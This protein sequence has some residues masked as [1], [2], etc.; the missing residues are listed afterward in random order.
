M[1]MSKTPYR[2]SFFGGGTDYPIWYKNNGGEVLSTTIDK[3]LYLTCRHLPPFF[4]HK[5]RIVWSQ[6]EKVNSLDE[7]KHYA[8]KKIFKYMKIKKG[9]ELHYDGDLPA[10]SGMG[11]SSAFVVGLMNLLHA[12]KGKELSKKVLA[13]KSLFIEQR[14]LNET[15]GSQ[16]QISTSY[17]GFNSIKFYKNKTFSVNSF[18]IKKKIFSKLEKNLFIVYSG[19]NRRA[20]NIASKYVY[21]LNKQKK[22]QMIEIQAFVKKAKIYLNKGMLDD[23]GYLIGESWQKKK[24]LSNNI[25]STKIDHIYSLAMK[26]G[27]L[28][29]KVL[30][31]GGGGMMVF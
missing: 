15:V 23:F 11:S 13:N 27:A 21:E 26:N 29:G 25:S 22:Q 8:V 7:I 30:G 12:F 1:I 18:S 2:I 14:I 28:G 17:G 3:Y 10:Q 24:E 4:N 16:D 9:L 5:H 6:I 20:N 31:A 19:I